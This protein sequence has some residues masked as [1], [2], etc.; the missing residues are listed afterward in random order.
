M[1]I[2]SSLLSLT[3]Y[4]AKRTV[5]GIVFRHFIE[6]RIVRVRNADPQ[7][8]HVLNVRLVGDAH[9]Y[10]ID[11]ASFPA[12]AWV[13]VGDHVTFEW[14]DRNRKA[15]EVKVTPRNGDAAA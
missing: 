11:L 10:Q 13:A 15:F 12:A 3:P 14:Q 8:E 2:M 4:E 5:S 7:I 1:S 9:T 6:A